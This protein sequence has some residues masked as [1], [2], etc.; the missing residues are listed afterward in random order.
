MTPADHL[1]IPRTRSWTVIVLA[2]VLLSMAG[3]S[4]AAIYSVT[5]APTNPTEDDP[6]TI[7]VAGWFGDGCWSISSFDCGTPVDGQISFD[8]CALDA[9]LPGGDCTQMMVPYSSACAYD[10]LVAGHY[11]VTVTEHHESLRAPVPDVVVTDFDVAPTAP[12][13]GTTWGRI[14]ALYR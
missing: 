3:V 12:V 2:T 6:I 11:V 4:A 5:I 14:R 8:V 7:T 13:K 10:Q 1:Q 9:W